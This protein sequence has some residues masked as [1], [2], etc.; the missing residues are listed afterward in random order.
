MFPLGVAKWQG[1][2]AGPVQAKWVATRA[3]GDV[4]DAAA[5]ASVLDRP[6]AHA[7]QTPASATAERSLPS[8]WCLT[9]PAFTTAIVAARAAPCSDL[10]R[11][12][13]GAS[14]LGR[15][16]GSGKQREPQQQRDDG[17]VNAHHHDPLE[18]RDPH[19]T[20]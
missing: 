9:V 13:A 17:D 10:S 4:A 7:A 15:D 8:R 16:R 2:V 14:E 1:T 5:D 3:C 12:L 19:A 18:R 20:F 6:R 11:R